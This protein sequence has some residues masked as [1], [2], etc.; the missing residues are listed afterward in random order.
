V[1]YFTFLLMPTQAEDSVV[2]L[3][4]ALEDS[5]D[6]SILLQ[7]EEQVYYERWDY[8]HLGYSEF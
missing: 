4:Q 8:S 3:T 1:K 5:D 7:L 2:D 6:E